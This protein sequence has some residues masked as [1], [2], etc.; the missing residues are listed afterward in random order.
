MTFGER[1]KLARESQGITVEAAAEAAGIATGLWNNY[2]KQQ[3]PPIKADVVP[4]LAGAVRSPAR[5]LTR[6]SQLVNIVPMSRRLDPLE[7]A[8]RTMLLAQTRLAVERHFDI[9]ALIPPEARRY[10]LNPEGFPV[11]ARNRRQVATI[12]DKLREI[13]DLGSWTP[14]KD[15]ADMLEM[16]G[17]RVVFIPG[18]DGFDSAAFMTTGS[19][20]VPA[21]AVN[22]TLPGD[23]QRLAMARE[24]AYFL[25]KDVTPQM[26]GHFAGALLMPAYSIIEELGNARGDV[27][28]MEIHML[29][30]KYGVSIRHILVRAV[31]LRILTVATYNTLMETMSNNGW[32]QQEPGVPYPS[33]EP[34]QLYRWVMRL[35][36]DGIIDAT[37]GASL[38][39]M[40]PEDW[41]ARL[42]LLN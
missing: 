38:L 33:E 11:L 27:E 24:L 18:L 31:T 30:H 39:G 8:Q 9:E 26:A 32:L 35:Q 29:K 22:Q 34:R 28:L 7:E 1:L 37:M 36:L 23:L 21:I 42:T 20:T 19:I 6:K 40:A 15:F 12:A 3:K 14:I 41:V 4:E 10:P 25:V 13:W 2:E 5:F 16:S 17:V